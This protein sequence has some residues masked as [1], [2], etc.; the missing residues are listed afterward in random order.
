MSATRVQAYR[1]TQ[2]AAITS[3]RE[4]DAYALTQ[5]AHKLRECQENWAVVPEKERIDR[6]FSALRLNGKLWS[7]FQAEITSDGNPLP[8]QVRQDLLSLSF[9]VDKRTKEIMC[10]PEPGKLTV[11]IN[12]NLNLAAGLSA[13]QAQGKPNQP[14]YHREPQGIEI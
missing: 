12:I 5:S 13:S 10:F 14:E 4:I 9:F 8:R 11:L 1:N 3:E 6:L 7:I 2:K